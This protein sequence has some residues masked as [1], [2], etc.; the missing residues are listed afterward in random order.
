MK[1]QD[2]MCKTVRSCSPGHTLADAARIM[3][4][5]DCGCV[6]VVDE[7]ARIC[8]VLTD[9]DICMAAYLR[10]R[11]PQEIRVEEVMARQVLVCRPKEHLGDAEM[12]MRRA[13]VRRL[14]VVEVDGSL[15]GILSLNDIAI[16]AERNRMARQPEVT[17]DEVGLTLGVVGHRRL[18]GGRHPIHP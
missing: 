4:D 2:L 3:S 7:A 9:R 5:A 17:L 13:Q 16:E 10:A 15:V 12:T 6:P 8:G 11:A 1:V 14:P 18:A